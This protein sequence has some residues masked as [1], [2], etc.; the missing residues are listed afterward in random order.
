MDL[1]DHTTFVLLGSFF[2][3]QIIAALEPK[4]GPR[5]I[6]AHGGPLQSAGNTAAMNI[7][8]PEDCTQ[9]C[10]GR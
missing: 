10:C 5:D 2:L 9:E 4:G 3:P 8:T 7:A 6:V 1:W